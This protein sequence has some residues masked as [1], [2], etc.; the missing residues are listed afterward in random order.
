MNGL[1]RSKIQNKQSE[2]NR[3]ENRRQKSRSLHL[4]IKDFFKEI[5]PMAFVTG[6]SLLTL[7]VVTLVMSM[8]GFIRY[9][10]LAAF[11]S[12]FA[13]V[14]TMLSLFFIYELIKKRKTQSNIIREAIHRA[15]NYRN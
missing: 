2:F 14:C 10:W 11:I 5:D 6:V 1:N 12:M 9:F 15:V 3:A 4:R 7:S 8:F 13:S